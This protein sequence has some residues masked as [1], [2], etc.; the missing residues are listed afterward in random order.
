MIFNAGRVWL[1]PATRRVWVDRSETDFDENE[2]DEISLS[3]NEFALLDILTLHQG[4]V[5]GTSVIEQAVWGEPLVDDNALRVLVHRLRGKLDVE[6]AIVPVSGAGYR[7][8]S[9]MRTAWDAI[10]RGRVELWPESRQ[11]WVDQTEVR[12]TGKLLE[13]LEYFMRRAGDTVSLEELR[14][15]IWRNTIE[16]ESVSGYV[17][18]LRG[19]LGD[20]GFI[21]R[22]AGGWR[23]GGNASRPGA[24]NGPLIGTRS[25]DADG[26]DRSGADTAGPRGSASGP[27]EGIS[28]RYVTGRD[29]AEL[30]DS[31]VELNETSWDGDATRLG[32]DWWTDPRAVP[33][34][35]VAEVGGPGGQLVGF[36]L[37]QQNQDLSGSLHLDTRTSGS[38]AR[39]RTYWIPGSPRAMS[40]SPRCW[41]TGVCVAAG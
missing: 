11:V 41:S 25:D 32:L 19:R 10:R 7:F 38:A 35:V 14:Q 5:V 30:R 9:G 20:P 29:L 21:V 4:R 8:D 31:V 26:G 24:G 2:L 28:F 13:L 40:T 6:G 3:D 16:P 37:A 34:A 39:I 12:V 18:T 33:G 1:D 36:C 27:E 15:D 23:F 22:V 17:S